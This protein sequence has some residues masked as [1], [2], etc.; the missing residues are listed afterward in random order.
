MRPQRNTNYVSPAAVQHP[1][2]SLVRKWRIKNLEKGLEDA[3]LH[4]KYNSV[5]YFEKEIQIQQAYLQ[6]EA[7]G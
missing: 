2:L 3:E 5:K 6:V 1:D 4:G 7:M